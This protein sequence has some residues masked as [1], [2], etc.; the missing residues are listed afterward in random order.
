MKRIEAAVTTLADS[1]RIDSGVQRL[2]AF[3]ADGL[4]AATDA[5]VHEDRSSAASLLDAEP[6]I[7]ALRLTVEDLAQ[8]LIVERADLTTG[9]VRFLVSVLRIVPELER[10]ADLVEHIA[11]RTGVLTNGLPADVRSLIADMGNSTTAMWRVAGTAW[12]ERDPS[13][14]AL[15][16]ESDDRIDDLHVQLTER[17]SAITLTTPE[18][19]ELGLVARFFER[20][21][22]HAVNVTSRLEFLEPSLRPTG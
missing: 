14:L 16:E 22:D 5:F 20:L 4:A 8:T 10:S 6:I 21:G 1:N 7:D 11:L 3:V 2:F 19:I 18:A 9:E 15:L 12:A 13:V 17:L